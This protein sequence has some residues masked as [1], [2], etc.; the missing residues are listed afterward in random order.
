MEAVEVQFTFPERRLHE[1]GNGRGSSQQVFDMQT[2]EAICD[3]REPC[4]KFLAAGD[5]VGGV[6]VD[7]QG[8]L[9]HFRK[10]LSDFR[11]GIGACLE[12]DPDADAISFVSHLFQR[13]DKRKRLRRIGF[14][15]EL[16]DGNHNE[17]RSEPRRLTN[18]ETD[19]SDTRF[20]FVENVE[21]A[22]VGGSDRN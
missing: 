7:R 3:L 6:V 8:V 4:V 10:E 17:R 12:C 2:D 16:T 20:E 1:A 11:Q 14:R 21:A 13:V 22:P 19:E 5:E 15:W 9:A 18:D